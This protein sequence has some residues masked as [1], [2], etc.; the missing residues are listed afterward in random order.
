MIAGIMLEY[1]I[2][3]IIKIIKEPAEIIEMYIN[4]EV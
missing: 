3:R 1:L 2:K 4:D